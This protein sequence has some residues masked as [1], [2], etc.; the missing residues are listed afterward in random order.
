V[1]VT[2]VPCM[3][4]FV[5]ILCDLD[6][7]VATIRHNFEPGARLV[8]AGTIQFASSLQAARQALAAD[9]PALAVPQAKPLSPGEVLGCTA[10][11]LAGDA[12]AIVFLADGRFHLEALMIAN[13]SVPAYRYDPY[14]RVLTRERYDHRGMR[15]VRRR[16]V[17]RARGARLWG[18]V[19]GTLG[20]QGNPRV[21]DAVREKLRAQGKELVTVLVSEV[22]PQ[23]LRA[24]EGVEAWVQV[25]C[26]RLSIDWGEGF[27][28]PT[29]TPFEAF[30]ALGAAPAWWDQAPD[31][32]GVEPYPMDYYSRDGGEWSSSYLKG[33]ARAPGDRKGRVL[34]HLAR[35][36]A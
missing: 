23:K 3:Y 21:V 14:P 4:V 5:D 12:D 10:P 19:M 9:F 35:K 13:P 15:D 30:V 27:E 22:S 8:L 32:D 34:P 31:A 2:R 36:A 6:H 20:R 11:V 29:L 7:L 24:F 25:A 17:E 16:M 33:K 28:L 18:V 26:P 1:D